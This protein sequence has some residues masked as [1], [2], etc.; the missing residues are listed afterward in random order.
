MPFVLIQILTKVRCTQKINKKLLYICTVL[1]TVD[2]WDRESL[3]SGRSPLP[4]RLG[5][6]IQQ[7]SNSTILFFGMAAI[8]FLCKGIQLNQVNLIS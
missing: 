6:E 2:E 1:I 7:G 4:T 3:T 5:V 8:P